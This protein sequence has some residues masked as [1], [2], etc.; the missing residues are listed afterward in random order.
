VI[1]G[2]SVGRHSYRPSMSGKCPHPEKVA[3]PSEAAA[4]DH[5]RA[6]IRHRHASP[7]V[8]PY[9]CRCGAWHVGHSQQSLLNRI[10][11]A[12][13]STGSMGTRRKRHKR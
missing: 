4:L 7:D 10:R 11:K 5:R 13:L 1:S 8:V 6:L 3:H 9:L 2:G 12:R